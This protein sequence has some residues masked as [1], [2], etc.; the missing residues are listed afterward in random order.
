M[1]IQKKIIKKKGKLLVKEFHQ[2]PLC[3]K[4]LTPCDIPY[5]LG[6]IKV[7]KGRNKKLATYNSLKLK[8]EGYPRNQKKKNM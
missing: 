6:K 4:T 2:K 1:K 5:G 7:Y 3:A 8:W